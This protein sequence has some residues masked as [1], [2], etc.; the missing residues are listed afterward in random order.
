MVL[1]KR[2]ADVLTASRA[3]LALVFAWLGLAGASDLLPLASLLLLISWLSDL[4]DGLLARRSGAGP[5]WV[6]D[7]DL[8]ADALVSLSVLV[9]LVGAEFLEPVYAAGYLLLWVVIFWRWGWRRDPAMLFQAPI[10]L[11]FILVAMRYAPQAGWWLIAYVIGVIVATWPRF[12]R[13]VVP[14]F[15]AGMR[16]IFREHRA[17]G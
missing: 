1:T 3:L 14:A 17:G 16:R 7:H 10:Y 5:T 6:G 8:E 11:W 13:E 4:F 9:Y 2:L 15:I 12:P